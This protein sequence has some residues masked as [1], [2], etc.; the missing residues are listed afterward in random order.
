MLLQVART[1]R[2]VVE[3]EPTPS[4]SPTPT[5]PP[6]TTLEE[7]APVLPTSF[8]LVPEQWQF[9]AVALVIVVFCIGV[10]V[11]VKL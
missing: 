6:V 11:V 8:E 7:P 4:P 2:A 9:I 3:P 10:L 1:V 5:V